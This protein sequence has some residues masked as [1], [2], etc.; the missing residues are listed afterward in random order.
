MK[1]YTAEVS[2]KE[3]SFENV[4]EV[5]AKANEPKQGDIGA[6]IAARSAAE[7]VA[8]KKVL[9]ELTIEEITEKPVIGY[10]ED[11]VTRW[12]IDSLKKPQYHRIRNWTI[13]EFREWL[14]NDH[15][16][17][18]DIE[19]IR[20]GLIGETAAAVAKIMSNMDL[21]YA[22]HKIIVVTHCNNTCG[23]PGRFGARL[24]PND[25]KDNWNGIC[26]EI[27]DGFSLCIG[28]AVLGINNVI[29]GWENTKR[30]LTATYNFIEEYGIPT[31]NCIL[32]HITDQMKAIEEGAPCDLMF[33][34][35]A[36][37]EATN[38]SFGIDI[39]LVDRGYEL[40]KKCSTA[41]GPDKMYWETGEGTELSAGFAYG[42]DQLTWEAR[43]YALARRWP[44]FMSD[45]VVGFIGPEYLYNLSQLIRAVLEN[46]FCA[47]LLGIPCGLDTCYTFHMDTDGVNDE[48]TME[49]MAAVAGTQFL[50]SIPGGDDIML[51]YGTSSHHD[52]Q[53]LRQLLGL[54][55]YPEFEKWCEDWGLLKDGVLSDKAGDPSIFLHPPEYFLE[56]AKV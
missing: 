16:K 2:G 29:S 40:M 25:P 45:A 36:G 31:Q 51:F 39:E 47:K 18:S 19:T 24:Q 56:E 13:S 50:M 12:E 53:T 26:A 20:W 10:N 38:R 3:H 33:Q 27:K 23:L 54:R 37:N 43:K 35:L 4:K 21:A 46:L 52:N 28:D 8:A 7:R 6:G 22:A 44:T 41:K 49:I 32:A 30:L 5:L 34:S 48:E 17:S 15:T 9:S 11:E 55:P 42:A 1:K 14:L